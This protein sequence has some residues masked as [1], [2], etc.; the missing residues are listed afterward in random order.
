MPELTSVTIPN[1]VTEIGDYAFDKCEG[2]TSVVISESVKKIGSGVFSA[3]KALTSVVIPEGVTEIGEIAFSHCYSLTSVVIP[4]GVE[5]IG[6][7]AFAGHRKVS[8]VTIPDNVKK[9][10]KSRFVGCEGMADPDGFVLFRNYLCSYHVNDERVVIPQGVTEIDPSFRGWEGMRE[11][12]I[13]DSVERIHPLLQTM[14][15]P[16]HFNIVAPLPVLETIWNNF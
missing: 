4:E 7:M 3:C 13:P 16:E 1:S 15:P 12:V 8:S 11:L 10:D 14:E 9:I 6:P 5:E 2:L